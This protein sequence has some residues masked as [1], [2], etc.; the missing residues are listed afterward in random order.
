[1]QVRSEPGWLR[2][3]DASL[4]A[5]K[6]LVGSPTDALGCPSAS[7]IQKGVPLYDCE[8]LR[9]RV[10]AGDLDEAALMAEWAWVWREGPGILVLQRAFAHT[11]VVDEASV[12]FEEMIQRE[13]A[14]G[15]GGDHFA[16]AGANDRVWNALEKLCEAD[17][18]LFARYYANDMIALAA[19]AWLGPGYQITSQVNNVRPGGAPQAPH[20]DYHL[21]F[22]TST[23]AQ[24]Y[25][26]HV[27]A[28]SPMLTLQ[29][30]V[31]HVDMPLSAG[32]TLY[33]PH[34]QKFEHGYLVAD[35]EVFTRYFEANCVQLPLTKGDV[36]FFNPALLHGAGRNVS[37][38]I[39]RMAN[40]LQISSAFGRAMESVNRDRMVRCLYPHLLALHQD[41]RL[42]G[43]ELERVVAASA[44][45][46]AFPTN[47]DLDPPVGG[48]AP[49]SPQ[50]VVLQ[51]L[52]AGWSAHQLEA[53]LDEMAGK[54]LS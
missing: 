39:Q 11:D 22:C 21:G 19:R 10:R 27:H 5:L 28:L 43:P 20:R 47:L 45:G 41:G 31:A 26:R 37:A 6:A 34:S 50:V 8:A 4:D 23:Q 2:R 40:L 3:E 25:P 9:T 32:P 35:Q 54:R 16:K 13:R 30:A 42:S 17:P 15:A 14:S 49:A 46:Y 7:L 18:A 1:M 51:A 36:V 29:G 12:R 38:D 53:R 44:E 48:L 33:L 24:A 52:E